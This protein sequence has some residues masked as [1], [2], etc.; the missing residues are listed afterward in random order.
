MKTYTSER[1]INI[2]DLETIMSQSYMLAQQIQKANQQNE[3]SRR[4]VDLL[5]RANNF[6]FVIERRK[7]VLYNKHPIRGLFRAQR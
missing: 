2:S 6:E 4:L 1:I 5:E 7:T 3:I